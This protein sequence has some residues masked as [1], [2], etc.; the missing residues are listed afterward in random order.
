MGAN[1]QLIKKAASAIILAAMILAVSPHSASGFVF[2]DAETSESNVSTGTPLVWQSSPVTMNLN[3]GSS[4][5]TLI[6][7]TTTWNENAGAALGELNTVGANFRWTAGS[8]TASPCAH[9]DGVNSAGW[10]PTKCGD[11]W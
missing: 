7:G 10:R 9:L 3:L 5:G 1:L 8:G 6:N 4:G 2:G 11:G